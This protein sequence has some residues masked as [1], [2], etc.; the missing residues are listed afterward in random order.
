MIKFCGAIYNSLT[1]YQTTNDF[2]IVQIEGGCRRHDECYS[3]IDVCS[4][5][6]ENIVGKEENAGYPFP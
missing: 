3:K 2:R 5:R 4:G 1:L 6:V